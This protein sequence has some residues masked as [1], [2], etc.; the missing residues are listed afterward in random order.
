MKIVRLNI[1]L[2]AVTLISGCSIINYFKARH[3]NDDNV[4]LW[5]SPNNVIPL[6]TEYLGNKPQVIVSINGQEGYRMVI[7]TGAS[8]SFLMDTDRVKALALEPEYKLSLGGVG[9]EERSPAFNPH[10]THFG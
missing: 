3:A 8:L 9:N 6:T 5:T 4:P 10:L 2:F 7:D 1:L